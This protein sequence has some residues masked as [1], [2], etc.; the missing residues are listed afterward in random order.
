MKDRIFYGLMVFLAV[1]LLRDPT[2]LANAE[3]LSSISMRD[4]LMA[5]SVAILVQPWV[6]RQID[7]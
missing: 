1:V 7:E 5:F 4:V 3:V 6:V 2:I